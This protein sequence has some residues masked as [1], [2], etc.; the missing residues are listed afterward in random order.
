MRLRGWFFIIYLIFKYWYIVATIILLL[1][2]YIYF[3]NKK[4]SEK[5]GVPRGVCIDCVYWRNETCTYE[6]S[7]CIDFPL[8]DKYYYIHKCK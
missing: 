3:E 7:Q 2:I 1:W 6:T 8:C 4:H 5:Y